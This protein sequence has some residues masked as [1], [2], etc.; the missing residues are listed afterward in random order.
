MT[1]GDGKQQMAY[2]KPDFEGY[3]KW[4]RWQIA[5]VCVLVVLFAIHLSLPSEVVLR[6][7]GESIA[8]R[9]NH[10]RFLI[11][12]IFY[13]GLLTVNIVSLC[14]ICQCLRCPHCGKLLMSKWLGRDAAGRNCCKRIVSHQPIQC[15]NCGEEIDTD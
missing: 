13:L 1:T 5:I 14:V 12:I 3:R 4:R 9:T 2:A 11:G 8:C 7:S 15:Y 6:S 10:L